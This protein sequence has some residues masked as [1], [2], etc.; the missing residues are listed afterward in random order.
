ML[1]GTAMRRGLAMIRPYTW[2]IQKSRPEP[3]LSLDKFFYE[4]YINLTGQIGWPFFYFIFSGEVKVYEQEDVCWEF[5][6]S[7]HRR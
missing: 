7:V 4:D 5:G 1:Q 3:Y 2:Y 6:I